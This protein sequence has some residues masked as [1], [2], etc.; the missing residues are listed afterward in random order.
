[1]NAFGF[2]L[3]L[4]LGVYSPAKPVSATWKEQAEAQIEKVRK[5]NFKIQLVDPDGK[6]VPDVQISLKQVNHDFRLGCVAPFSR[7]T[8]TTEGDERWRDEFSKHFNVAWFR[9]DLNWIRYEGGKLPADTVATVSAWLTKNGLAARGG[10]LTTGSLALA[11]EAV[12]NLPKDTLRQELQRRVTEAVGQW[13][14][15][16]YG[17]DV[18]FG[19]VKDAEIWSRVGDAGFSE[20][21]QAAKAADPATFVTYTEDQFHSDRMGLAL[22]RIQK[23]LASKAPLD[24]I[25]DVIPLGNADIEPTR[26]IRDWN[27]LARFMRR[28]EVF[29]TW[30]G[31]P[32]DDMQAKLLE[33]FLYASFSQ[34]NVDGMFLPAFAQGDGVGFFARSDWSMRPAMQVM[35]EFFRIK[36]RS[37]ATTKSGADG[38][39]DFNVFF[40]TYEMSV[41]YGGKTYRGYVGFNKFGKALQKIELAKE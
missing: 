27:R 36:F 14:G 6:A 31:E 41:T 40:G 38:V 2:T 4:A 25:G 8:G 22:N 28:L 30:M 7:I 9:D 32:S 26:M 3:I 13:K 37:D 12:R 35:D 20:V 39:G 24:I 17:W 18:A 29:P 11:P 5:G 16:L 34:E 23:L 10:A 1:M 15:K 21:F 19:G 33:D